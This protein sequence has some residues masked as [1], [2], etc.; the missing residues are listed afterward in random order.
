VNV[1]INMRHQRCPHC[2]RWYGAENEYAPCGA[3][4]RDEIRRQEAR[5]SKLLRSNAALRGALKRKR[6]VT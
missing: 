5:I 1:D 3:C 6:R 4:A 2:H